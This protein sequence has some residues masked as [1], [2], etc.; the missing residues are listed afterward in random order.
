MTETSGCSMVT[1]FLT[2][3]AFTHRAARRWR[4]ELVL[5]ERGSQDHDDVPRETVSGPGWFRADGHYP[6]AER[7]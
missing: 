1:E 4:H 7:L 3:I 5:H 2:D 6:V